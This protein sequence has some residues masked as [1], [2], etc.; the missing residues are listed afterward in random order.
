MSPG[1]VNIVEN[2]LHKTNVSSMFKVM[3]IVID[4]VWFLTRNNYIVIRLYALYSYLPVRFTQIN[5]NV[6]I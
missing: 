5:S 6:Y 1:I 2:R 4:V 3:N